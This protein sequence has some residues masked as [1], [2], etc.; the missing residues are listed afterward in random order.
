MSVGKLTSNAALILIGF[1]LVA[2][3][4][5]PIQAQDSRSS[6]LNAFNTGVRTDAEFETVLRFVKSS[7]DEARWRE[8]PWIPGIW[9]GIKV[10]E[11]KRKPLFVWAMNGDPLGCV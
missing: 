6:V 10:A 4:V 1:C 5:K 7:G 8:I 11:K 3:S 9:E 2:I